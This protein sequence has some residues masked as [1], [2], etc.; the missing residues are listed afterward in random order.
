MKLIR[1][2]KTTLLHSPEPDLWLRR[3]G[4]SDDGIALAVARERRFMWT[5]WRA[6]LSWLLH[7]SFVRIVRY[8]VVALWRR[9]GGHGNAYGMS[10][11]GAS[12]QL[13]E[14]ISKEVPRDVRSGSAIPTIIFQTWK[15]RSDIPPA[16]RYWRSTF[17]DKN[18]EFQCLLWDDDDN[19]QFISEEFPWFLRLYDNFPSA[20]FRADAIRPF[21]L[22]RYGGFYVDMDTEC[23]MPLS[24]ISFSGDVILGRM[25]PDADFHG[26]IPNAIMASKA[27]QL[28]WPLFITFMMEEAQ[29]AEYSG[30]API[31]GPV[32]LGKAVH[33][34]QSVSEPEIRSRAQLVID[35][36]PHEF[37]GRL[38]AGKLELLSPDV[39]YPINWNNGVHQDLLRRFLRRRNVILQPDDSRLLFPGSALV[40]YWTHTW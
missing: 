23:L 39:W 25:G 10:L 26:S 29:A 14:P 5:D 30:P 7:G 13:Y 2:E 20:I 15:S 38:Q 31:T 9:L 1:M 3:R 17:V 32:L 27:F 35:L 24:T 34:Y 37:R 19:R 21:F 33:F 40:T 6:M 11:E 36:L 12:N 16:L 4:R 18:Q 8:R 22:F 28:F